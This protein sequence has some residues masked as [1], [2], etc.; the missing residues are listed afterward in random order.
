MTPQTPRT[1]PGASTQTQQTTQQMGGGTPAQGQQQAQKSGNPQ[2]PGQSPRTT[3][4][5][6]ASI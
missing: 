5:D 1:R 6:W 2:Q 3:F 4:S